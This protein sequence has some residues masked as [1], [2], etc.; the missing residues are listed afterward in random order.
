M[1]IRPV[2]FAS[3]VWFLAPAPQAQELPPGVA[4]GMTPDA[5]RAA[6][7]DV[8]RVVRPLRLAGGLAGTWRGPSALVGEVPFEPTFYF[9]GAALRRVEWVALLPQDDAD[10]GAA[11]YAGLVEWGRARFGTE[12]AS[13]DPG[14]QLASWVD[15]DA[16]IYAQRTDDGRRPAGVR[17]VYK[18]RQLKDGSQ[19]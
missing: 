2:L 16:D 10:R 3:F 13:R 9:A 17:L 8:E 7:P 6:L 19:L 5:L 1:S 12:M 4:L 11:V 18:V 15:G 14:S